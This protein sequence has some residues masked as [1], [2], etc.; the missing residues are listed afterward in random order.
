ME[1]MEREVVEVW[2]ME[3]EVVALSSTL[4]PR[5]LILSLKEYD[6]LGCYKLVNCHIN[7]L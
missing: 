3:R 4:V 2:W 7:E 1:R 6:I 5:P